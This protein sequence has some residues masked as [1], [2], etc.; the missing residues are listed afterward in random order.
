MIAL[1]FQKLFDI[2][3]SLINVL[4]A[5]IDLIIQ[6]ALPQVA[7]LLGYVNAMIDV[8]ITGLAYAISFTM[9]SPSLIGILYGCLLFILTVPLAIHS[10]KLVI[11][12]YNA[13]KP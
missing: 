1:L 6:A 8:A 10:I 7:Q 11:R 9:L 12:W 13:L 3:I 4:L 5:P 2:I